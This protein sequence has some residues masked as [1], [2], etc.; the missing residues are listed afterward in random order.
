MSVGGASGRMLPEAN[1]AEDAALEDGAE[2]VLDG[3]AGIALEAEASEGHA[4]REVAG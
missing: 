2:S 1:V 4:T 3:V